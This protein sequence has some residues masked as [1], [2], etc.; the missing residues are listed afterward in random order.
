KSAIARIQTVKIRPLNPPAGWTPPTW[1]NVT[2]KTFNATPLDWENGLKFWEVLH[3]II[4]TEPV[5]E[6]YRNNYGELAALGII[7]GKP[8]APDDRMKG[9]LEQAAEIGNA[10]MRV[11]SLADRRPDRVVWRDRKSWEWASLRPE[12]G[13]F[14]MPTYAAWTRA[15]SGSGRRRMSRPQCS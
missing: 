15:R 7:K 11:Q 9:I 10:Q 8:F 6:P 12:N 1:T 3:K 5:Y 13:T 2:E 4:D 14:D